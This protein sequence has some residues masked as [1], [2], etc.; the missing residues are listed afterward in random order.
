[1]NR[2]QKGWQ[3][4][5]ADSGTR[6]GVFSRKTLRSASQ[7]ASPEIISGL[8][9]W[10]VGVRGRLIFHY[11]ISYTARFFFFFPLC[12]GS[13]LKFKQSLWLL[14]GVWTGRDR[15]DLGW[16]L[17]QRLGLPTSYTFFFSPLSSLADPGFFAFPMTLF[18]NFF[19][20]GYTRSELRHAGS[21][22]PCAGPS[23]RQAG[24]YCSL[25]DLIP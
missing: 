7:V 23:M 18:F 1:M 2:G 10:E 25:C 12:K 6:G 11:I 21:P 13:A 8:S 3:G 22:L 5:R 17:R 4:P 24:S 15:R 9:G 20:F 16:D 14:G 19:F